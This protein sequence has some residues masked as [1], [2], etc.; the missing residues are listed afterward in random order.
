MN[1]N[2]QN[3]FEGLEKFWSVQLLISAVSFSFNPGLENKKFPTFIHESNQIIKA[4][5]AGLIF[6]TFSGVKINT[7][8]LIQ[9]VV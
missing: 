6:K 1:S 7:P 5:V 2:N 9:R 3:L 4:D 8:L